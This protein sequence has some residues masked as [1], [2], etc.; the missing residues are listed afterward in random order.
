MQASTSVL[1]SVTRSWARLMMSNCSRMTIGSPLKVR[2]MS[3]RG[4][5]ILMTVFIWST[6]SSMQVMRMMSRDR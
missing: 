3:I 6:L 2:S 4:I 1:S 5:A